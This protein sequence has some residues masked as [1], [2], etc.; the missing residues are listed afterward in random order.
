[1]SNLGRPK[2]TLRPDQLQLLGRIEGIQ[3]LIKRAEAGR[4]DLVAQAEELII[5]WVHIGKALGVAPQTAHRKYA[6][7]DKDE[8]AQGPVTH[9]IPGP[10]TERRTK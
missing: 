9:H 7:R 1:M 4:A 3:D 10:S 6:K 2:T 5:P 8:Q